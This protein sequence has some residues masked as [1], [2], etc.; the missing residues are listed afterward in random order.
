MKAYEID[1]S[2]ISSQSVIEFLESSTPPVADDE[3]YISSSTMSLT[4]KQMISE[5]KKRSPIGVQLLEVYKYSL[6]LAERQKNWSS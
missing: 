3:F 1:I 6:V 2:R 5:M 4:F